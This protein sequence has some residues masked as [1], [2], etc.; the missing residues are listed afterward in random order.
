M[1]IALPDLASSRTSWM[2]SAFE[3]MSIPAVG[4]SR[5]RI[6]GSAG[7]LDIFGQRQQIRAQQQR[8]EGREDRPVDDDQAEIAVG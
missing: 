1:T 5:M 7:L 3:P 4:S 8:R 6:S 2:I